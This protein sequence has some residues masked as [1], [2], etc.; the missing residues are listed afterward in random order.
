MSDSANLDLVRSIFAVWERGDYSST[1]WAD[2]E[3][4]F[5]LADG[6]DPGS[7]TGVSGMQA[8]WRGVLAAWANHH[9]EAGEYRELDRE[10]VLWIG[11]LSTRGKGSGLNLRKQVANLFE[12]RAGK[13][14]RLA[15]YWEVD[16]AFADL[17]LAPQGKAADRPD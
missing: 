15:L 16:R 11:D 4:E 13:V 1:E 17:G 14:V 8:A 3:I 10:R 12:I 9:P 7:W 2:P 6:L 5:V